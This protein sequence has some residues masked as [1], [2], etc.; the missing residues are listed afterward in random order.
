MCWF[1]WIFPYFL[2]YRKFHNKFKKDFSFD[3]FGVLA[4][5]MFRY[6]SDIT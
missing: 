3:H 4:G 1:N 5:Y 2:M 6:D